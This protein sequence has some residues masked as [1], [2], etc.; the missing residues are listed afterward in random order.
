M[1]RYKGLW[2]RIDELTPSLFEHQRF[3]DFS[4]GLTNL[5]PDEGGMGAALSRA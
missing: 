5:T 3:F 2:D 1:E 4:D